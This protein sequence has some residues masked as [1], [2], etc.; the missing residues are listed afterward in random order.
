[1]K[2]TQYKVARGATIN[3]GSFESARVDLEVT[4]VVAEND[5]TEPWSV[6]DALLKEWL[7]EKVIEIQDAAG[8]GPKPAERFTGGEE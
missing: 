5:V 8:V 3:L 1:M 6:A 2:I 7:Q 4:V